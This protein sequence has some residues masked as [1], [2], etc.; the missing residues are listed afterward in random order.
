MSEL[1]FHIDFFIEVP[2]LEESTQ[3]E[4]RQ[5]LFGLTEAHRDLTGAAVSVEEI[6]GV[7][8][9]FLYQARIVAYMRPE[10]I[11]VVEK[12][13]TPDMALEDAVST[14]E[15]RIQAERARRRKTWE[16]ADLQGNIS[17]NQL[18]PS[19]V[20]NTFIEQQ[21]P[22]AV[23]DKGRTQIATELMVDEK[24]DQEAAYHASDLI[25]EHA[26]K[27]VDS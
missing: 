5:R 21:T 16:R 12:R 13:E 4:T 26:H 17:L 3:A 11:A 6:A 2:D 18:M 19:E 22:Q 25:L 7:E 9:P 14:L 10:N 1:D 23:I 27:V 8:D 24:L 15:Q 20:Y